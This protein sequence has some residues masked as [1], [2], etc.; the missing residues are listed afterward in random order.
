MTTNVG[1]DSSLII[2]AIR[3]HV[4]TALASADRIDSELNIYT[5]F[6]RLHAL[7]S[8]E[9]FV[10]CDHSWLKNSLI[11]SI[12]QQK[13]VHHITDQPY[14]LHAVLSVAAAHLAALHPNGQ[15]YMTASLVHWQKS[16]HEYTYCLQE[17]M[18]FQNVDALFFAGHL[19]SML[20]TTHEIRTDA[21]KQWQ[22]PI[23]MHSL[24]GVKALWDTPQVIARLR[25]GVWQP[26]VAVCEKAYVAAMDHSTT[27][28]ANCLK[29]AM[30]IELLSYCELLPRETAII[31]E[32]RIHLLVLLEQCESPPEACNLV[33]WFI[34]RAPP[35]YMQ[36]LEQ[37][38]N[39][40]LLLL[41]Y[42]C[43][44]CSSPKIGQWW[45]T[46][47]VTSE[48]YKIYLHLAVYCEDEKIYPLLN[49]IATL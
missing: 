26:W 18:K 42:W 5:P 29:N 32:G 10:Q 8:L 12:M 9:H 33:S 2:N 46:P 13:N 4:W 7:E 19:H 17:D 45:L 43:R 40:A 23:W 34:T 49:K 37:N 6:L 41:L 39:M 3:S 38:N 36:L 16:L 27:L 14:L 31:F 48:F 44:L 1:Q 35:S 30:I 11:Q 22:I 21:H 28:T 25:K 15:S 20:A 24:R 47:A